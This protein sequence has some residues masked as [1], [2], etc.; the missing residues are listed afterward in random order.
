MKREFLSKIHIA[1]FGIYATKGKG[2]KKA[3]KFGRCALF[4]VCVGLY[5]SRAAIGP[6]EGL[7]FATFFFSSFFRYTGNR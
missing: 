7:K 4:F 1:Y 2:A 6:L 5:R 3:A